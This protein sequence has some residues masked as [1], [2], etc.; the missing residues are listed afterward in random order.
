MPG[1]LFIV[2]A[3]SGA[4]K[5]TLV[6]RL[7]QDLRPHYAIE[8]G[9]TYTSRAP[10]LGEQHGIDYH[11][12]SSAEFEAKIAQ[13][14]F[15]EW[16]GQYGAYYGLPRSI[17][18]QMEQGRSFFMILDR[19]GARAIKEQVPG[20]VLIWIKTGSVEVLKERLLA[21][22]KDTAE[23]IEHRLR[24]AHQEIQQEE[25]NPLFNHAIL[26]DSFEIAVEN[27]KAITLK[28]V[29]PTKN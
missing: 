8:R 24:L 21:R 17:I 3:P 23:Q 2:S 12:I 5:T 25:E 7:L 18:D 14:F 9:I 10:R 16:S 11:F 27:L 19:S 20:A 1:K 13:S 28:M 6:T 4:G 15:L 26:N 22:G 29:M